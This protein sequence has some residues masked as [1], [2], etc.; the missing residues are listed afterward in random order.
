MTNTYETLI[1]KKS[2]IRVAVVRSFG[3][4]A[5]DLKREKSRRV[6]NSSG[7][8]RAG[9]QALMLDNRCQASDRDPDSL[10]GNGP[11]SL[12]MPGLNI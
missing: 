11:R 6:Q 12:Q 2:R 10:V 5:T 4:R 8:L 3:I 9:K 7:C 1:W